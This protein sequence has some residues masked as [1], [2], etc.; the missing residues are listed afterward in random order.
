MEQEMES[1][2]KNG[3]W[4]LDN[5][6]AKRKVLPRKWAYKVKTGP[7]GQTYKVRWVAKGYMQR[8]GLDFDDTFASVAKATSVQHSPCLSRCG[9]S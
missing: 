9:G 6:P 2:R 1:H 4:D 7:N 5:L 3:T 8:Q